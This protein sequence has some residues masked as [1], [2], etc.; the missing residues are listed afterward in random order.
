MAWHDSGTVSVTNGSSTVTGVG[1][2]WLAGLRPGD[3]LFL[4]DGW[5]YEV[6][7]I[8]SDT[9]LQLIRPYAGPTKSGERYTQ[10]PSQGYI[11]LSADQLAA[12]ARQVGG[13]PTRVESLEASVQSLGTAAAAELVQTLG[14]G[15]NSVISQVA[16]T[17][18]LAPKVEIAAQGSNATGEWVRYADGTMCTA[19]TLSLDLS[20]Q[21]WTAGAS[22]YYNYTLMSGA[23]SF[24]AEYLD[25]P[26]VA[27]STA[28][29]NVHAYLGYFRRSKSGL[30]DLYIT[31]PGAVTATGG[32]FYLDIIARGRWL[33]ST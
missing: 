20:Q 11:K 14:D 16:V 7:N 5:P 18:A 25:Q 31:R 29:S 4:P 15:G 28:H 17:A 12:V 24:P 21:T 32:N 23:I 19:Q 9:T 3:A 1:T 6:L 8:A 30:S 33:A 13:I 10:L 26:K 27:I 22:N 2:D